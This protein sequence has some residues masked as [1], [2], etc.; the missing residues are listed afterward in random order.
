MNDQMMRLAKEAGFLNGDLE[1][2]PETI[3]RFAELVRQ[4]YL[5]E[6]KALKPV[7]YMDSKGILF[8]DTTHP[9]LNTAL[10][11]LDKVTK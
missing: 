11:A 8:N 2:F 1:L 7:A 4:D 5:R 10:Y 3:K 9:H 6:L